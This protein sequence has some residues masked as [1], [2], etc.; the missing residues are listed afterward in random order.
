M[1]PI[2]WMG[3][4]F[5]ITGVILSLVVWY[6][7]YI[8]KFRKNKS[9]LYLYYS[10][11]AIS[12]ACALSFLTAE[13]IFLLNFQDQIL[14][15]I[16]AYIALLFSALTLFFCFSFSVY[17]TYPNHFK[18][19]NILS[20]SLITICIVVALL[21]IEGS[22][23]T[24]AYEVDYPLYFDITLLLTCGPLCIIG[25]SIW[26]HYAHAMKSKSL[27][28]SRRATWL[29]LA[30]LILSAAYLPEIIG[31]GEIINYLRAMWIPAIVIVYLC[32]ARFV[33]LEWPK[34]VRHLYLIHQGKGIALYNHSFIKEQLMDSQ[35]VAGGISGITVLLRE[36]TQSQRKVKII[37]L[38]DLNII[39]EYGDYVAGALITEEN[40]KIL[41]KKLHQIIK[42]FENQY[43]TDLVNF[44]G[45]TNEFQGANWIIDQVF[46]YERGF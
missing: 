32:F 33:E 41:R 26:F 11:G 46:Q 17:A 25:V 19:L 3:L 27:P 9:K 12:I 43:K 20:I 45:S 24:E 31:F 39:M 14:G 38:E 15:T 18:K 44:V 34:K 22:Q 36:L 29:G 8:H 6:K 10:L 2:E 28:H 1:D 16:T 35:I 21:S 42:V 13:R 7:L 40:Y 30:A 37:D 5:V 23:I 4:G